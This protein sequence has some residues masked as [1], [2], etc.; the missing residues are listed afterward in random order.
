MNCEVQRFLD[1]LET[2]ADIDSAYLIVA[3]ARQ[4]DAGSLLASYATELGYDFTAADASD[5]LHRFRDSV[6]DTHLRFIYNQMR[7]RHINDWAAF[8][9][10]ERHVKI[11]LPEDQFI[12][13]PW[14]S[15]SVVTVAETKTSQDC[16]NIG[17]C[18]D[19]LVGS[20]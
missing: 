17:R 20:K 6:S 5:W 13:N 12:G 15:D 4:I 14:L 8:L 1:S 2:A 3:T 9:A 19:Y 11:V 7:S 18:L 10:L 16:G